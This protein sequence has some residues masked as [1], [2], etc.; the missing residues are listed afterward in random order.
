MTEQLFV[1]LRLYVLMI[2]VGGISCDARPYTHMRVRSFSRF[3]L[4]A[5]AVNK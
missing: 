4:C 3:Y 1:F 2:C 5:S